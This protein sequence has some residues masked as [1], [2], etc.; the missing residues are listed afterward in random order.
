MFKN[1]PLFGIGYEANKN[2]VHIIDAFEESLNFI[3]DLSSVHYLIYRFSSGLIVHSTAENWYGQYTTTK[4][5][6]YCFNAII[7][8]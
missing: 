1:F 5:H 8:L 7:S 2:K 6:Y 4:L 3:C